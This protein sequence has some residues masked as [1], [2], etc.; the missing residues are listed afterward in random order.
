[1][2]RSSIAIAL[3]FF[4]LAACAS[5]APRPAL[6]VPPLP[7]ESPTVIGALRHREAELALRDDQQRALRA[8]D[9][10]LRAALDP[11]EQDRETLEHELRES[12]PPRGEGEGG[13]RGGRG[14]GGGG[15]PPG[16]MG[17]GGMGGGGMGGPGG[18]MGGPGG[19]MGGPG[20]GGGMDGPGG[21]GPPGDRR[22]PI[23]REA[24]RVKVQ[25]IDDLE[26][27][28]AK[29]QRSYAER[30]L[31]GFDEAQR[32]AASTIITEYWQ[33]EDARRAERRPHPPQ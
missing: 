12:M 28:M 21:G 26:D 22:P 1:M 16:G 23:D 6:D 25:H 3:L 18:G 8:L 7:P 13:R 4:S 31:A 24:L 32:P 17:G 30:A 10:E 27:Q 33:T 29:L 2:S 20:G 14:P 15:G 11:L 5:T 9:D 19:G